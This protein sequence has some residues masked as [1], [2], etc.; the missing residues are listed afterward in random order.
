MWYIMNVKEDNF[1]EGVEMMKRRKNFKEIDRK[2]ELRKEIVLQSIY[3]Q[4]AGF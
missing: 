4:P 1:K 2:L 3:S